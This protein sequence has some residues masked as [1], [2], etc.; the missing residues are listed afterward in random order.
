MA[1]EKI[2]VLTEE[3]RVKL[4]ERGAYS[5][6]DNP[7][8]RG[9]NPAQIKRKIADP[10]LMLF[11]HLKKTQENVNKALTQEELDRLASIEELL[12]QIN[13]R[14]TKQESDERFVNV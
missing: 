11:D 6:P 3:E 4:K 8:D 9:W 14:Y 2:K 12:T 10:S 13:N 5:L 7:S 1:D